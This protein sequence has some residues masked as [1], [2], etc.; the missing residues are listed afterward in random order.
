MSL[1]GVVKVGFSRDWRMPKAASGEYLAI[2]RMSDD[3]IEAVTE[4][5][6][7]WLS[8]KYGVEI[9]SSAPDLSVVSPSELITAF[10]DAFET[11]RDEQRDLGSIWEANA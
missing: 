8:N 9:D 1:A 5:A 11:I 2:G 10:Q 4:L 3:Q 7:R 6:E